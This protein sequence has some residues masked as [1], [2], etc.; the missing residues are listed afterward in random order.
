MGKILITYA[1]MSG[2]TEDIADLLKKSLESLDHKIE[3]LEIEYLE[4]TDLLNYDGIL[5]GSYTWGDGDLPY[6]AEDF[7]EDLADMDLS[8]KKA[9]VFGSGDTSYPKFCAAVDLFEERLKECGAEVIEDGIKMEFAPEGKEEIDRCVEF[10]VRF[11][12]RMI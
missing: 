12:E 11:A 6:E 8:G 2:N 4:P 3:L 7:Y 9:A 10:A 1:S 5:I